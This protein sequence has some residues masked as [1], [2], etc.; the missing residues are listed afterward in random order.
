MSRRGSSALYLI[1]QRTAY[2]LAQAGQAFIQSRTGSGGDANMTFLETF[3]TSRAAGPRPSIQDIER[4]AEHW[5]DLVPDSA[6]ARALLAHQ[7]GTHYQFTAASIPNI[8]QI[9]GFDDPAVQ[10]AYQQRY[11]A[12]LASIYAS[13]LPAHAALQQRWTQL[14]RMFDALPPF[15]IAFAMTLT[16][17]VG[18]GVL[19]LPI[20]IATVGAF[21]GMLLLLV[22]G[23]VNMVTIACMAEV[24]TRNS[25]IRVT[26][27]YLGQV[28]QDVLGG[29]GSGIL[30]LA[31]F[32]LTFLALIAYYLG[33]ATTLQA[34]S[35]GIPAV[36]WV[37]LIFGI[38]LYYVRQRT[39][40]ATV[41][42]ALVVGVTNVLLLVVI[43]VLALSAFDL[44]NMTTM[45]VPFMSDTPLT[46]TTPYAAIFGVILAAYFGHLS[47][48][49][50]ARTVL[51]RDPGG[52][53]LLAGVVAAQAVVCSIYLIW[54]GAVNGAVPAAAL[55]TE[56]G[57]ALIP[58][59]AAFSDAPLIRW[60]ITI[61]GALFTV[62]AIGM[63]SVHFSLALFNTIFERLPATQ[64][65]TLTLARNQGQVV[66][67]RRWWGTPTLRTISYAG[68]ARQQQHP[69]LVLELG[70]GTQ[71]RL[72]TIELSDTWQ[73]KA[74]ASLMA[75]MERP[76]EPLTL[77]LIEATDDAITLRIDTSL[78]VSYQG[79]WVLPRLT[80]SSL[81]PDADADRALER[82]LLRHQP[83]SL[84]AIAAAFEWDH[85]TAAAHI[86]P[87]EQHGVVLRSYDAQGQ[88]SYQLLLG[89]TRPRHVDP[90]LMPAA[91]RSQPEGASASAACASAS[92]Q[93]IPGMSLRN[94]S[95]IALLPM[96]LAF[97][98]TQG[99]L[100]TD[101]GSFSA[102]WGYIGVL[103]VAL[104]TGVFPLL[105]LMVSRKQGEIVPGFQIAL[106]GHPLILG[107]IYLLS[108][109]NLL[110]HGLVIWDAPL[111]RVAA[112]VIAVLVIVF[113][114][115]LRRAGRF[116]PRS[117]LTIYQHQHQ[118]MGYS[119]AY[120]G[121]LADISLVM[122]ERTG[123]TTTMTG[124]QGTLAPGD[125]LRTITASIPARPGAH[126]KLWLY[127]VDG[128]ESVAPLPVHVIVQVADVEHTYSALPANGQ[129]LVPTDGQAATVTCTFSIAQA[130]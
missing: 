92:T 129:I 3:A 113:P 18:A 62:L 14:S 99:L 68:R 98:I 48:G 21:P 70:S 117:I 51:H 94:R 23:L 112:L 128:P 33:F 53:S 78:R 65:H 39:L 69:Q 12:P 74:L 56:P 19:A 118:D 125:T 84:E 17:T 25:T 64:V 105:L 120:A 35:G 47:V 13:R 49:V 107:S 52:R 2:A 126:L 124:A 38:G 50:S 103:T 20:A 11:H 32:G 44:T 102:I 85:A 109:A 111:A 40:N 122:E 43:A 89:S 114:F 87:L 72:V 15:W 29:I 63:V 1:E 26:Q 30:S 88:S 96:G 27:S 55:A 95:L 36:L 86:A 91:D 9:V 77:T 101:S 123:A 97:L 104:L 45:N 8:R 22:F 71:Y 73:S 24:V 60:C 83:A 41:T 90:R 34:I 127:R 76:P 5:S 108:L 57:T 37:V 46:D 7:L 66:L 31:I 79:A 10:A 75:D 130:A 106:L 115:H 100:F 82:W 58:L 119:F 93:R 6:P 121:Q 116:Q 42:T 67:R 110:V 16:E 80:V 61:C 54:I 81:L 59:E 4:Y 28:V